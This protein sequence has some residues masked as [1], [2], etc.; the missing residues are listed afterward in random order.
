[1]SARALI[2]E[3]NVLL[4]RSVEADRDGVRAV[5]LARARRVILQAE[6]ITGTYNQQQKKESK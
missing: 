5:M 6:V 1:M 4:R 2:L 3:A